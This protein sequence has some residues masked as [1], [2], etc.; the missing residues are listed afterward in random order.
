MKAKQPVFGN[1]LVQHH[2]SQTGRVDG[3]GQLNQLKPVVNFNQVPQ[4]QPVYYYQQNPLPN[5]LQNT[6]PTMTT[7]YS[8]GYVS[9]QPVPAVQPLPTVQTIPAIPAIPNAM[10]PTYQYVAAY[11]YPVQQVTP[12]ATVPAHVPAQY[13]YYNQQS[14]LAQYQQHQPKLLP[15]PNLQSQKQLSASQDLYSSRSNQLQRATSVANLNAVP[16]NNI[17]VKIPKLALNQTERPEL[18]YLED[19]TNRQSSKPRLVEPLSLTSN[20]QQYEQPV[21]KSNLSKRSKNENIITSDKYKDLIYR[22]RYISS[23]STDKLKR[24]EF[25]LEVKEEDEIEQELDEQESVKSSLP[26]IASQQKFSITTPL[27]SSRPVL[28][29]TL[30]LPKP[31][32]DFKEKTLTIDEIN[33]KF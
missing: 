11:S 12:A 1:N 32:M 19:T 15:Q 3:N 30:K 21:I 6:L 2:V 27:L 31:K 16:F 28:M 33:V 7:P 17:P 8:A 26:S 20:T 29:D 10:Q 14:Q 13:V 4:V 23:I 18:P 5:I 9:V 25:I 22:P 24:N